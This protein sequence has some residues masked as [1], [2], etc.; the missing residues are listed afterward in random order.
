LFILF[1]AKNKILFDEKNERKINDRALVA[2]TLLIAESNPKD[3]D[4]MVKLVLN[5]IN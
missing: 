4:I 3:K 2:I 1:L 5:L